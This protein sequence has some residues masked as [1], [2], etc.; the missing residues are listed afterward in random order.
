MEVSVRNYDVDQ[1]VNNIIKEDW[2][3]RSWRDG[4]LSWL[5]SEVTLEHLEKSLK[6]NLAALL[7]IISS[8]WMRH[9]VFGDQISEAYSRAVATNNTLQLSRPV[10]VLFDNGSQHSYT[11]EAVQSQLKL[12][13]IWREGSISTR[14]GDHRFKLQD[15]NVFKFGLHKLGSYKRIKW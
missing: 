5:K 12:E 11:T 4:Q 2:S 1:V 3:L 14:L 13:P 8:G 6:T 9:C 10:R 15:Y 7:W